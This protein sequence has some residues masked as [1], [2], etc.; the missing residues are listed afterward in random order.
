MGKKELE[1]CTGSGKILDSRHS[2]RNQIKLQTFL[3]IF[4]DQTTI[5]TRALLL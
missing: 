3:F 5:S 2:L 4:E 1:E